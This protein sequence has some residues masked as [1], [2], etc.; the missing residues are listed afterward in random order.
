[1]SWYYAAVR[2]LRTHGA[3]ARL[4]LC[5]LPG[6]GRGLHLPA[7]AGAAGFG[8]ALP[9]E[10]A[11]A[12]T[13]ATGTTVPREPPS[14]RL[15]HP[16]RAASPALAPCG[17]RVSAHGAWISGPSGSA[18]Q[19]GRL[20]GREVETHGVPASPGGIERLG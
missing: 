16:H 7:G 14:G 9:V 11:T 6:A 17:R 8:A 12:G 10:L 3:V 1:M 2:R 13:R 5:G 15:G 19:V 4:R 20:C 18:L